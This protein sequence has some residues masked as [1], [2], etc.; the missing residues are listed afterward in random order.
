MFYRRMLLAIALLWA[1][2]VQAE[3]P[4]KRPLIKRDQMAVLYI[5]RDL[6][7]DVPC[8]SKVTKDSIGPYIVRPDP[9]NPGL[10]KEDVLLL[11]K[12][13]HPQEMLLIQ[14]M[15]M[16]LY[17]VG[18]KYKFACMPYTGWQEASLHLTPQGVRS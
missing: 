18:Y 15:A 12:C 6:P 7:D 10:N 5:C 17:G 16:Q 14:M 1:P 3:D 13:D 9:E 11:S 2:V 4:P 8:T